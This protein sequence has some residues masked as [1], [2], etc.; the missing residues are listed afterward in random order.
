MTL[1]KE[2]SLLKEWALITKEPDM[3]IEQRS[4]SLF[5][6]ERIPYTLFGA[7]SQPKRRTSDIKKHVSQGHPGEGNTGRGKVVEMG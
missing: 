6:T 3:T 4:Q 7:N 2:R 5:L 1:P